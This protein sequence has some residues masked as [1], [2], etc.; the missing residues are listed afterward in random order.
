MIYL[1]QAASSWPKPPRVL[2]AHATALS[3]VPMGQFRG[4]ASANGADGMDACRER[5]GALLDIADSSR[6]YFSSGATDSA[7][8][9]ICGL[10]LKGRR[11][12]ATQTEHNSVL[13][14]LYNLPRIKGRPVLL[15]CDEN[16]YVS[17]AAFE[18]EARKGLH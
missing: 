14:P 15:P 10:N 12:L 6:I 17:P 16:G 7:N 18:E 9:L 8:A 1:N 2:E 11:V 13:R 4:G 3:D 5:L